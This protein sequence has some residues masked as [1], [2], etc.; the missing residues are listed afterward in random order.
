MKKGLTYPYAHRNAVPRSPE[1]IAAMTCG[2]IPPIRGYN[3]P[4]QNPSNY[5]T[6]TVKNRV[7]FH[8][9]DK[10][11]AKHARIANVELDTEAFKAAVLSDLKLT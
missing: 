1:E 5:N 2:K 11:K 6:L 3:A 7:F 10:T 4:L 8:R 9:V